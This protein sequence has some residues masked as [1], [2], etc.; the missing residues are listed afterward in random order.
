MPCPECDGPRTLPVEFIRHRTKGTTH[1]Y[2]SCGHC[3]LTE[4]DPRVLDR[5]RIDAVALIKTVTSSLTKTAREPVAVIPD[6]LWHIGKVHLL[7]ELREFFFAAGFRAKTGSDVIDY[8]RTRRRCVVLVPSEL[9][10]ARWGAVIENLVVAV[11]SIASC[12]SSGLSIDRKVLEFLI[13]RFFG[14]PRVRVAARRRSSRLGDLEALERE[15]AE[16]IRAARDYAIH[17][18]DSGA[19]AKLLSRPTKKELAKR[20]KV[21]PSSVT[22]CFQD[23]A[24]EK[25][26]VLWKL[27]ADLDAI[28]G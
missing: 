10:V 9:G 19:E 4:V 27:A 6:R 23:K 3:G 13:E 28:L 11:E 12:D 24:G 2:I 16:H 5:W 1:G 21:S 18:R 17:S 15:L 20:A 22:R 25:L 14:K 26:R 7:G 8:L